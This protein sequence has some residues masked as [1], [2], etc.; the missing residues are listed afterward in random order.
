MRSLIRFLR[1]GF[2]SVLAFFSTGLSAQEPAE[3]AAQADA[4]LLERVSAFLEYFIDAQ[5]TPAQQAA[6]FAS[7]AQYYEHGKADKTSIIRDVE[8]FARRWP[9]RDY[10]LAD[11]HY[12]TTD[13][14]SDRVFVSYEIDYRVANNSRSASG[15]AYY[16]AVIADLDSSPKIEWIK[17]RVGR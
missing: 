6:L 13:P 2:L 12:I 8:H 3:R 10:H 4:I 7:D 15:K 16:G 14:A 9:S 5:K 17:E 11:I 1:S